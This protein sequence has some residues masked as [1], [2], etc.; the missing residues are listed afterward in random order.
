M[1]IIKS[2]VG[3]N[4]TVILKG[5][6]EGMHIGKLKKVDTKGILV[7]ID[8]PLH[9]PTLVYVP[10]DEYG[11]INVRKSSQHSQ[12]VFSAFRKEQ[13]GLFDEE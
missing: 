3:Y 2:L 1:D 7:L 11:Q 4:V 8:E 10:H 6:E 12:G 13:N 5:P 9:G